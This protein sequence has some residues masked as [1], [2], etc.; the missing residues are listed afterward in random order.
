MNKVAKSIFFG[1]PVSPGIAIG[2]LSRMLRPDLG[3]TQTFIARELV[4]DELERLYRAA[5]EARDEL[6][7]ARESV[8]PDLFEH[9]EIIS[10][11]MLICQ[12]RKL[13]EGAAAHVRAGMSAAW[14]L[15]KTSEMLCATFGAME[16]PYLRERAQDIRMVVGRIQSRLQGDKHI[17]GEQESPAVL[18]AEEISPADAIELRLERILAMLTVAGGQTTHTA[19]FARSLHIPAVVGVAGLFENARDDALVIVDALKGCIYLEPDEEELAAFTQRQDEYDQWKKQVR[20]SAPLPAETLDG[21]RFEVQANIEGF[22]ECARVHENGAE[23][24]GLCRTEFAYL[25]RRDLPDEKSLYEEYSRIVKD[26]APARVV[27]RTLDL[28]ADKMLEQQKNLKESNPN[29]GLRAIRFCLR[30]QNIFRTQLR[31]ILRAAVHGNVALMLPMISGVQELK[32]GRHIIE[33]VAAELHAEALDCVSALPIGAMIEVPSSVLVADALAKEADFFSI[34]TNDL[35]HYLLAIDRN[36]THVAYLHEPMH[37]AVLRALKHVIDC[38][39]RE[40]INVAVCGELA[41]DPFY[42]PVLLGMGVDSFSATPQFV[43]GIKH[44]IRKM[45]GDECV[46]LARAV[47]MTTDVAA[48][49]RMV[50]ETLFGQLREEVDFHSSM[51][52]TA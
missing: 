24:V 21:M 8:S 23:G 1:T 45:R 46:E 15:E 14:A 51:I 2:K 39:H 4:P 41:A 34:G 38:A 18:L 25:R 48:A 49:N 32:M 13:L 26:I 16:D 30:H 42:I 3:M 52:H 40:G 9:R 43:P 11:H 28:G 5:A 6:A 7:L 44:L 47:L 17:A 22:K 27:F 33:E 31:A 20:H 19:I 35:V 50:T 37:S 36:N 12:D 10:S 29:L